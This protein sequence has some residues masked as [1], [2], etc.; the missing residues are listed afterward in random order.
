[1]LIEQIRKANIEAM[2]AHDVDRRAAFSLVISAYQTLASSGKGEPS[3]ADVVRIIQKFSKEL[4]EEAKGYQM[5]GRQ[6]SYE[7]TLRQKQAIA[8]FLPKMLSE[9]EIRAII[10]SL[11]DKSIPAV[12]KHFKANYDGQCDMGLVSRIAR[13]A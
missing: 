4:D 2:K 1:M 5:A 9:E 6:E 3:D 7:A 12:M 10:A 8:E 11:D 13:N